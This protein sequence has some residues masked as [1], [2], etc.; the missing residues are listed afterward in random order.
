MSNKKKTKRFSI[1]FEPEALENLDKM[2]AVENISKAELIRRAINFYNFRLKAKTENQ[3]II[4]EDENGK[5]TLVY[6]EKTVD[7]EYLFS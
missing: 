7:G 2:A 5:Q 1:T 6:F 4:L 3:K